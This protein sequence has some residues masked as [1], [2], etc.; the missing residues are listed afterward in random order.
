MATSRRG[1]CSLSRCLSSA[2]R[3]AC[4]VAGLVAGLWCASD[5]AASN[6]ID[7]AETVGK[8]GAAEVRI[9]FARPVHYRRH[10]PPNEGQI[11]HIELDAPG[12]E[13]SAPVPN[14][15]YVRVPPAAGVPGFF[16]LY[17]PVRDSDV[18]AAPLV[19]TV[20]FDAP[21]AYAL[22]PGADGRSLILVVPPKRDGAA[23]TKGAA[24]RSD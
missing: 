14:E 21:T 15:E 5:A 4:I 10:A 8:N 19:L 6:L 9:I 23:P 2:G 24:R 12:L 11:V 17:R 13:G 18:P 16:V 20:Q 7:H 22:R 3:E 1:R